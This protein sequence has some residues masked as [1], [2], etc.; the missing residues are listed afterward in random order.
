MDPETM[1]NRQSYHDSRIKVRIVSRDFRV[2]LKVRDELARD[3]R[4]NNAEKYMKTESK[5]FI[6]VFVNPPIKKYPN[7]MN[8]S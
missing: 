3:I 5:Y 6:E 2:R 1:E 8:A 7:Q 4:M